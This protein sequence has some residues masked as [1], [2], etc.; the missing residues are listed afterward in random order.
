MDLYS[1][2]FQQF[3]EDLFAMKIMSN[4]IEKNDAPGT[5]MSLEDLQY[6]KAATTFEAK[7]DS[8]MF[9]ES[10]NGIVNGDC[11]GKTDRTSDGALDEDGNRTTKGA[12]DD[13]VDGSNDG[14]SDNNCK[15]TTDGT[16][17]GAWTSN[18][19][20]KE[21]PMV[22]VMEFEMAVLEH[23]AHQ[24]QLPEIDIFQS[25]EEILRGFKKWRE[26][27]STSPSGCHLGL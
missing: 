9:V 2:K 22:Q 10:N 13:T 11:R 23:I 19:D 21:Q 20:C 17:N 4:S 27:T 3:L 15:G 25:P 26:G 7:Q 18:G 14:I 1:G 24:R 6:D 8:G 16:T 12:H 5:E